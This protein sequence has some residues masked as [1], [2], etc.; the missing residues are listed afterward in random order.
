MGQKLL[1]YG[2][3][4]NQVLSVHLNMKLL[5]SGTYQGTSEAELMGVAL[6]LTL[7]SLTVDICI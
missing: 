7:L 6:I 3:I 4:S 2:A 5:I 1:R